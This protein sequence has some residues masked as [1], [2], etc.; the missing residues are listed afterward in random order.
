MNWFFFFLLWLVLRILL[1]DSMI[2]MCFNLIYLMGY[3]LLEVVW[4]NLELEIT[5]DGSHQDIWIDNLLY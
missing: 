3:F 4:Y 2:G 5:R 1:I